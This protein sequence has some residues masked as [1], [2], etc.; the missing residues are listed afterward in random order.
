MSYYERGQARREGFAA[1]TYESSDAFKERKL[2][3]YWH[4]EASAVPSSPKRNGFG[5]VVI[6][7]ALSQCSTA[8]GLNGPIG[9]L[10]EASDLSVRKPSL[11]GQSSP[12]LVP[13]QILGTFRNRCV[14]QRLAGHLPM[15]EV[16]L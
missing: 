10:V 11:D 6:K 1:G 14:L 15:G 12:K 7:E 16:L 3:F 5:S 4:E 13:G 8:S 9:T 2:E